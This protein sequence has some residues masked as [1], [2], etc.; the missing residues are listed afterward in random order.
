MPEVYAPVTVPDLFEPGRYGLLSAVNWLTPTDTHWMGGVQYDANCTEVSVT[1]ME[2]ISGAPSP[3][4][5]KQA[6]WAQITRG[7]R[8][9]TVYSEVDCTPDKDFWAQAQD[10]A[11]RSLANAGPS[12]LERTFQTG[13]S[14]RSGGKLIYPNLTTTGP[15][16]D[17][18]QRILLQPSATIISGAPLDIV[19]GLGALEETLAACWDGAGVI[20]ASVRL[21]NALCARNLVYK[22]GQALYTWAGNRVVIGRGYVPNVGPGGTTP[23]GGSGWLFATGPIFGYRGTPKVYSNPDSFDRSVNTLKMIAEQT[24]LLGWSCCLAAV[25]V[26]TGGEQAGEPLSPLQDT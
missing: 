6:T 11:L 8:P 7:A 15:I 21:G 9:F 24:Y 23:P 5:S 4:P 17:S 18:T 16:R 22:D 3:V 25:L 20:H 26:T 1:L 14:D 13:A 10:D 2:C 12:Q 19:E